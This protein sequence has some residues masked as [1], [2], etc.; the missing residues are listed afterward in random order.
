MPIDIMQK[1]HDHNQNK[2]YSAQPILNGWNERVKEG[3]KESQNTIN[4]AK[5]K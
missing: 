2:Q 3:V 5:T 1:H 4:V